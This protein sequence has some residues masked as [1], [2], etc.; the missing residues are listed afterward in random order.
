MNLLR[1]SFD[2]ACASLVGTDN[3]LSSSQCAALWAALV[4]ANAQTRAGRQGWTAHAIS[5]RA[6]LLREMNTV[7]KQAK[8]GQFEGILIT[9]PGKTEPVNLALLHDAYAKRLPDILLRLDTAMRREGH[10]CVADDDAYAQPLRVVVA[11]ERQAGRPAGT[12]D[13]T[14]WE[15]P[16][17]VRKLTAAFA[18]APQ[19]KRGA[20]WT[21]YL[22]QGTRKRGAAQIKRATALWRGAF[23]DAVRAPIPGIAA[24]P[25]ARPLL[26]FYESLKTSEVQQVIEDAIR[27]QV[28]AS[29]SPLN[30]AFKQSI[31]HALDSGARITLAAQFNDALTETHEAM[32]A[33]RHPEAAALS[34]A[35][36]PNPWALD[37]SALTQC[38]T[39]VPAPGFTI[40]PA[41]TFD[42]VSNSTPAPEP[43]EPEDAQPAGP[44]WL[45][46]AMNM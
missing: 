16:S 26:R 6:P 21:P 31:W 10:W 18:L 27:T 40:V 28:A 1:P 11:N 24:N 30:P 43:D 9:P 39:I 36:M 4:P 8:A 35:V 34:P 7:A 20:Q 41:S 13:W 15:E 37:D 44:D 25:L 46:D 2:A 32:L 17:M 33:A 12:M 5:L 3:E 19:A 45:D 23:H 22:P 29:R 38:Q 42:R 14:Q